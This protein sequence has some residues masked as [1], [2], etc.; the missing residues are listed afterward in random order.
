MYIILFYSSLKSRNLGAM[1]GVGKVLINVP[2]K[3]SM[4]PLDESLG[5]TLE[6]VKCFTKA[7]TECK[8]I[9]RNRE[10]VS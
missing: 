3:V 1:G 7:R 4:A 6:P 5:F 2:P 10:K 9:E 8:Q